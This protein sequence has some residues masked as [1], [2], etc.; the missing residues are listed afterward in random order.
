AN[1]NFDPHKHEAIA[2]E[3]GEDN[4]ILEEF[5][6]GYI[7]HEK[8]IRPTKVKVGIKKEDGGKQNE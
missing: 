6:K 1:G 8:V 4:K 7:L 2:H 5:Q 3:E